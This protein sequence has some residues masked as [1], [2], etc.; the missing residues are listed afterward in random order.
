[1]TDRN[2][3]LVVLDSVRAR[4]LGLYGY[5][6]ETTPFLSRYADRA[7]VY[8]QARTA[9]IHSVASHASMWTG[10]Q[11][12]EHQVIRHEDCLRPGTTIWEELTEAGYSTGLFTTNPVVAHSSNL[13]S[14]FDEQV[15]DEFVDE[16][17]KVFPDAH[18]PGDVAR[19][20]GVV[21]NLKRCLRD[22]HPH[23]ALVNSGHHFYRKKQKT[24]GDELSSATLVDRFLEWERRQNGPWAACLNLMDAH[25]PY[26]PAPM[27]DR[28]GGSQLRALHADL[29]KPPANEFIGGRPWWQ[30]EVF[31][32]LYD[33]TIRQLDDLVNALVRGIEEAGS[34]EETLVVVTSD[35]GEGF[36]EI[37]PLTGRTKLVDHSWGIHEVVTHVPLVV[38]Y[39]GQD[40]G[41]RVDRVAA[42]SEFPATVRA[43]LAGDVGR[44]SFAPD[45]PVVSSTYRLREADDIIFEGSE[46]AASDYHGPWRAVYESSEDGVLKYARKDDASLTL[47]IRDAGNNSIVERSDGGRVVEVFDEMEPV[48]I[49]ETGEK[50]VSADVEDRLTE[51][52]YLR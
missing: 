21:G 31:E 11:V 26:E 24:R 41:E 36:G 40:S 16:T 19:H 30:L 4:N 9:G 49:K 27:H 1:M 20:E 43:T 34:H 48:E 28:W 12:A 38:K 51:L 46:E 25:F 37:S 3:L 39:P 44:D 45:G 7:T 5:H 32:H 22:D 35:H 47:E 17:G 8:E 52:G 2:V 15:T 50:E 23:K 29:E 14:V 6:R 33:G 18:S 10:A 13:A 42:L